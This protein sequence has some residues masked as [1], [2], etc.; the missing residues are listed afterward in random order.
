[1]AGSELTRVPTAF[2]PSFVSLLEARRGPRTVS[3]VVTT[4]ADRKTGFEGL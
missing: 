1:M 4:V 2:P 3:A